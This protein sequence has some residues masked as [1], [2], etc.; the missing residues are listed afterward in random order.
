MCNRQHLLR[1]LY[2]SLRKPTSR[3]T[4]DA[5]QDTLTRIFFFFLSIRTT[6][7]ERGKETLQSRSPT[8]RTTPVPALDK[9]Q[10]S[11]DKEDVQSQNILRINNY[12]NAYSKTFS[13]F[14][15]RCEL[16]AL[17]H[18]T[19][20]MAKSNKAEESFNTSYCYEISTTVPWTH[21]IASSLWRL[22]YPSMVWNATN[23]S[24]RH[25]T[26][27]FFYISFYTWNFLVRTKRTIMAL[28]ARCRTQSKR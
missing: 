11:N 16:N 28:T 6:I 24:S 26:R 25:Y 13:W 10:R 5:V 20:R 7:N 23:L 21:S 18:D 2:Q 4:S 9:R 3:T 22:Q 15:S 27:K 1:P 8:R 17:L 19:R 14:G 12:H